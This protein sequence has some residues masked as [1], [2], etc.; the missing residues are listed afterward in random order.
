MMNKL[1]KYFKF[2]SIIIFLVL[3]FV[4]SWFMFDLLPSNNI[5]KILQSS[6]L[7]D[8]KISIK[9]ED[10][11]ENGVNAFLLEEHSNKIVSISFLFKNSGYAHDAEDKLGLAELTSRILLSGSSQYSEAEFQDIL[12]IN[13]INLSFGVS[14]DDFYGTLSFPKDNM[15]IALNLFTEAFYFPAIESK[16]LDIAKQKMITGLKVQSENPNTILNKVFLEQIYGSHPYSRNPL[17]QIDNILNITRGDIRRYLAD[18]LG[19]DNLIVGIAGD[20]DRKEAENILNEMFGKLPKETI[21]NK[22][23]EFILTTEGKEHQVY[24]DIPQTITVFAIEGVK[25]ESSEFYPLYIANYIFGESGLNSKLSKV[26]RED[27]SLTYGIYTYLSNMNFSNLI[28]GKFSSTTD[29]FD[30]AMGLLKQQ[31]NEFVINGVSAE[32]LIEAK[33]SLINSFYL[34]FSSIDQ[35]SSMLVGMQKYNLGIDF[36]DKRNEYIANVSLEDVN[37]VIKKYFTNIPDFIMIGNFDKE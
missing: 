34:R 31:W 2:V 6:S 17:G 13:A 9:V 30:K 11:L 8:K 19:K 5:E 14:A 23:P 27:N 26:L 36:L 37:K 22:L 7:K 35:L 24:R 4:C 32:E 3:L 10:I 21:S 33:Q 18:M 15:D 1:K 28:K 25:R 16:Y 29:N 20:V 12:E